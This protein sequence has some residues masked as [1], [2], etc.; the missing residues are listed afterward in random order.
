M[1]SGL[2]TL[3]VLPQWIVRMLL[4]FGMVIIHVI[5][6]PVRAFIYWGRAMEAIKGW[7]DTEQWEMG[8][9][10]HRKEKA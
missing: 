2:Y 1:R 9:W 3:T 10:C 8:V 4:L 7:S 6:A 5:C